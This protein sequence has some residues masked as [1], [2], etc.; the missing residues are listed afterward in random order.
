MTGTVRRVA[1]E[2]DVVVIGLGVGGE[3]L[4]TRLAEGGC[5]VVGIEAHLVGGEC[6]YYGC[7][8]TKMIVRAAN[9]LEEA[10]RVDALAGTAVVTP[11]W[12]VVARRIRKDA[13]DNWDDAVAVKRLEDVGVRVVKGRARLVARDRV[14][15]GDGVGDEDEFV[16]T[17]AVVIATGSEPAIPPIEGLD[18]VPY[19]TNRDVVALEE[20]PSSLVVMGGGA[21]GLE[22]AQATHRFGVDVTVVEAADRLAFREEPEASAL[23]AG[24]FE[25]EGI[26]VRVGAAVE[27]VTGDGSP[28]GREVTLHLADGTTVVRE[29]LLVATGRRC[30]LRALGVGAAGLDEDART[31]SVDEH[32]R[33]APGVYAI[34]DVTGA[35]AF[36]HVAVYHSRIAAASI[37]G[38]D[39][40]PAE[41]RAIPRVTFTDPEVGSV[42]FTEA[43]ARERGIDVVIGHADASNSARGWMHAPEGGGGNAELV[44]LVVDRKE[45]V[46]VGAT[47][48]GPMGGEVLSMLALAVHARIPVATLHSMV[49][50]YPTF[51]RTIESALDTLA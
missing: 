22:I 34:G 12:G 47:V 33:A 6:P 50:A 25:G 2:V 27:R 5:S 38:H 37:L 18:A 40:Y 7:V 15:V 28:R 4:S 20:L 48:A 42:G 10:R 36:T 17:R 39:T 24:V 16:A 30:D 9:V 43:E 26:H 3:F 1:H 14:V 41:T 21:I 51:H 35:G 8:P 46:L 31:I 11:D 19:L 45:Q 29:R 32:L 44:K 13:T 23:L 49:F